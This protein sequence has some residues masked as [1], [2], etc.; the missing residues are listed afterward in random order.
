MFTCTIDCMLTLHISL[1]ANKKLNSGM[2]VLITTA[3]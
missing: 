1:H 2:V 3:C